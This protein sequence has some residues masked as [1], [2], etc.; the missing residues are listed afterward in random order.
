MHANVGIQ[1]EDK[2]VLEMFNT[3]SARVAQQVLLAS[4]NAPPHIRKLAGRYSSNSYEDYDRM[5]LER[6]HESLKKMND[7]TATSI[8]PFPADIPCYPARRRV[9]PGEEYIVEPED[10]VVDPLHEIGNATILRTQYLSARKTNALVGRRVSKWFETQNEFYEGTVTVVD[11][12][13]KIL[14]DDGDQEDATLDE[15]VDIIMPETARGQ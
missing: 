8:H 13:Y 1:L 9:A 2:E 4:V 10:V 12:Y 6:L 3:H 11:D 5:E 15:L 7:S 14:Y